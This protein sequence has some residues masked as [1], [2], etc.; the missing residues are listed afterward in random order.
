MCGGGKS[1]GLF[2]NKFERHFGARTPIAAQTPI[3]SPNT[4][5]LP[6]TRLQPKRQ[7][8]Y[9]MHFRSANAFQL[10]KCMYTRDAA[11]QRRQGLLPGKHAMCAPEKS[12]EPVGRD[13][14]ALRP[15]KHRRACCR[16]GM[17]CPCPKRT[18]GD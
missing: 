6:I 17:R 4:N 10:P 16:G 12:E 11:P 5:S 7:L 18:K 14:I 2:S 15:H 3:C 8:A 13:A 1:E 9:L